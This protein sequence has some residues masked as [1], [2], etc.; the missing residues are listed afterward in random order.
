MVRRIHF[1]DPPERFVAGTVGPPG[2][3][4][5]FL[6]ARDSS[7]ITSVALEKVQVQLLAEKIDQMLD[8]LAEDGTTDATIPTAEAGGIADNDPLDQP[9]V[10]EF[11]VG[12][13][14]LGWHEESQC[15]VIEA[16]NS[17][18]PDA[19]VGGPDDV[20]AEFLE[21]DPDAPDGDE[22]EREALV[23]RLTPRQARGFAQRAALL[24]AAGRPPCPFCSQPLD[25]EGH[26]C[27]RQ[28]GYKRRA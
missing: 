16:F 22:D 17:E 24:V 28:N 19:A 13:L 1:F 18:D 11:R 6:Q 26:V 7:H 8:D 4:T 21:A 23:V 27:P 5:F 12:N 15:V 20:P 9:L 2:Q 14:R 25:P 10:E 3:R